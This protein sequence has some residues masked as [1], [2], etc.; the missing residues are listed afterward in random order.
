MKN[1]NKKLGALLLLAVATVGTANA[2]IPVAATT[3]LTDIQTDGLAMIDAGWPVAAAIIGGMIV[4]KLFRK[5]IS[6]VT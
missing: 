2:A 1:L 3:A 6:K 5:V 4:I